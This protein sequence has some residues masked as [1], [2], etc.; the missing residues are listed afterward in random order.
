MAKSNGMG[1]AIMVRFSLQI[2]TY[3]NLL[4]GIA[5]QMAMEL[6]ALIFIEGL[7]TKF[8]LLSPPTFRICKTWGTEEVYNSAATF[9]VSLVR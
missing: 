6:L 9:E 8:D 3:F 7:E 4:Y 1:R 5:K 2:P